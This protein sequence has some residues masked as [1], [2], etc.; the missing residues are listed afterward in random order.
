MVLLYLFGFYASERIQCYQL[1]HAD[2]TKLQK[3]SPLK[4]PSLSSE[5][6]RSCITC[7]LLPALSLYRGRILLYLGTLGTEIRVTHTHTHITP[8]RS[9]KKGVKSETL[10]KEDDHYGTG[11]TK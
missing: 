2:I 4:L 9:R 11:A 6:Q 1:S 3:S 5:S 8:V 10:G 7:S